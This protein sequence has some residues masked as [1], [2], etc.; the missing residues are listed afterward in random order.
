MIVLMIY[1]Y[2]ATGKTYIAKCLSGYLNK[3]Y[4]VK[5]VSTL[6]FRKKYNL[7]DLESDDERN[8]VY[9]MLNNHVK[10]IIKDSLFDILIVDGNFNKRDRREKLYSIINDSV[11]YVIKCFVSDDKIIKERLDRRQKESELFENKAA[12]IGLYNMIKDE[13][14]PVEEDELVKKGYIGI[15]KFDSGKNIVEQTQLSKISNNGPLIDDIL[16]F[17]NSNIK[18]SYLPFYRITQK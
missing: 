6:E 18:S 4:N 17:L 8:K 14:V 5:S 15:I 13:G 10:K 2:P 1:G 9:E 11:L 3:K 12:T 7:F 16:Y